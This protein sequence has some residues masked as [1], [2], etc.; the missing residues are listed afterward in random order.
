MFKKRIFS[1]T[2]CAA[3][4]LLL[5]TLIG[6]GALHVS[7]LGSQ[8]N[9]RQV[10]PISVTLSPTDHTV[11]HVAGELCGNGPLTGKTIQ[12][13]RGPATPH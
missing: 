13:R 8:S 10:A 12:L 11:Y 3:L 2:S 7:A 6:A 1:K 4:A 9:C 5:T